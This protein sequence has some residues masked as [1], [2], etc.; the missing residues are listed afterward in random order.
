[1]NRIL[2]G[3]DRLLVVL[4]GLALVL[5]GAFALAYRFGVPFTHD[6]MRHMNR[7]WYYTAPDQNWWPYALGIAAVLTA[8]AGVALLAT[9]LSRRRTDEAVLD[10][11]TLGTLTFEPSALACVL[12]ATLS[13]APGVREAKAGARNQRG[14]PTISITLIAEPG[15]DIHDLTALA[16]RTTRHLDES[17]GPVPLATRYF[18]QYERPERVR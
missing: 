5:G 11:N 6:W 12:A 14:T 18:V 10:D 8:F 1:M 2:A 16:E 4:A 3:V 13:A 17:I 9:N 7:L 15:T